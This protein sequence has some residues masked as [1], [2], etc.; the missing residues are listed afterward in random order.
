MN[1][2]WLLGAALT[3]SLFLVVL[4]Y[5]RRKVENNEL[6]IYS[7]TILFNLFFSLN[8]FL[9]C[10]VSNL[11]GDATIS[12]ISE[13]FHF[14]FFLILMNCLF[15]YMVVMNDF[16]NKARMVRISNSIVAILVIL[17]MVSPMKSSF[18]S[19]LTSEGFFLLGFD[20]YGIG[21]LFSN[22]LYFLRKK[23]Y[24][25]N[26]PFL[27]LGLFFI[28]E[29]FLKEYD[30]EIMLET[31]AMAFS[32]L[33]MYFTIENPDVKMIEE[34]SMAKVA[35]ERANKAKTEFL[36]SMSHEI[37][38]PL[39]AIVGFSE[40][41]ESSKTLEEA[42]ENAK[43]MM[44]ASNT[45][46]EIVNGILDISK[47]ESG[48]LEIVNSKYDAV[49]LFQGAATLMRKRME[50]KELE[51]I[52]SISEDIPKTLYGNHSNLKKVIIN[53]L[54][55]AFKYTDSGYVKYEVTCI[56]DEEMCRLII[57]IEDSGRGIKKESIDKLFTKFERLDEA[58]NTTIEGTGLGL[59]ITKKIVDL[60][61]GKIV[62]QSDYKKGSKFTV[63]IDQKIMEEE[64]EEEKKTKKVEKVDLSKKKVLV[65][66]DNTLNLKVATKLLEKY[67]LQIETVDNGLDCIQRIK[68]HNTYD[69]LLLDDMMPKKSG[70][71]VLKE[72]KKEK[73][74]HIP[75]IALTAN[76][77]S[78]MREEY[79]KAGFDDY[80]PKPI[81]KEEL[82]HLIKKFLVE[83]FS[84][85]KEEKISTLLVPKE[86]KTDEN[87][88]K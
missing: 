87:L 58:K 46:L 8:A 55:N 45:L 51:F 75:T 62:V 36:S 3:I 83:N 11:I 47:I 4:F 26:I 7:Y 66:D 28:L 10:L 9:S 44:L 80:L 82:D 59:A 53:L 54:S 23:E 78:G 69:L 13:K 61:G 79:L 42:K 18:Y 24:K 63:I 22:L 1:G 21:I 37:R 56:N 20:F 19:L 64:A 40:C 17:V 43:D 85:T 5:S 6:K 73:D 48:K 68:D 39:N 52:V 65:V 88:E 60:M 50:E 30:S 77:I 34:L 84:K 81:N 14:S 33:V 71:E 76:A 41:I 72:L 74:F 12:S 32:L 67:H 29:F 38:T 25:K 2:I 49:K 15:C 16:K 57:N 31:Y 70:V 86:E 27:V 35:A